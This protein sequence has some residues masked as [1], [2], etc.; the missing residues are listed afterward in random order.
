MSGFTTEYDG[1]GNVVARTTREQEMNDIFRRDGSFG[2][3]GEGDGAAK[4]A[5]MRHELTRIMKVGMPVNMLANAAKARGIAPET[6]GSL[7]QVA[8]KTIDPARRREIAKNV[9]G[10]LR[11][12]PV[13]KP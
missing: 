11:T 12:Q 9:V 2:F 8:N 13:V 3:G 10:F 7:K 5:A 6:L 1:E 4:M